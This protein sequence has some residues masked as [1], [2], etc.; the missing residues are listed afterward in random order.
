MLLTF[1]GRGNQVAKATVDEYGV[2]RHLSNA[3]SK[4]E[5]AKMM[6]FRGAVN[7]VTGKFEKVLNV[8]WYLENHKPFP[9]KYYW[10]KV[11]YIAPDTQ[12]YQRK[13]RWDWDTI[14]AMLETPNGVA[15]KVWEKM[16]EDEKLQSYANSC[17][18]PGET[19]VELKIIH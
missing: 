17:M 7:P 15:P 5:I 16:T 14:Q 19:S 13:L 8:Q 18:Q 4:E 11:P 2:T 12:T 3:A 6:E 1:T 9:K 10:S